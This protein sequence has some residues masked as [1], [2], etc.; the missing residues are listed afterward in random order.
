MEPTVTDLLY[1]TFWLLIIGMTVVFSF[2]TMLIGGVK[3]I[4]KFC[5]AF[6]ETES[7]NQPNYPVAHPPTS[8]PE[9]GG[10]SP[11]VVAAIT[12]AVHQYRQK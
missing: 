10:V 8:Q 2:L 5:A 9:E 11:Q 7:A 4:E 12:A 3:L 6:P 1:E